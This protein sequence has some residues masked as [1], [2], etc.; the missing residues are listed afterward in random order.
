MYDFKIIV[1]NKYTDKKI[2]FNSPQSAKSLE[3]KLK[4][5]LY[6]FVI[7]IV[8]PNECANCSSSNLNLSGTCSRCF[9]KYLSGEII[10]TKDTFDKDRWICGCY[11]RPEGSYYC[12]DHEE[13][14]SGPLML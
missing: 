9:D 6:T 1:V 2:V 5:K 13:N 4:S 10:K 3:D 14:K 8:P 11:A 7:S 12:L